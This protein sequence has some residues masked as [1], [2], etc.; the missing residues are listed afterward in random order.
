M[1]NNEEVIGMLNKAVIE[2]DIEAVDKIINKP[3]F[4][5]ITFNDRRYSPLHIAAWNGREEITKM[6]IKAGADVNSRES[7]TGK[8]PIF[9]AY[10]YEIIKGL[11]DA[12]ADVNIQDTHEYNTVLHGHFFDHDSLKLF[13]DAGFNSRLTNR[14]GWDVLHTHTAYEHYWLLEALLNYGLD[15]DRQNSSGQT[16]M[17]I[18]SLYG[19]KQCYTVLERYKLRDATSQRFVDQADGLGL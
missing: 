4:D 2:D 16:A 9:N 11:I 18:A 7:V 12:G 13:F 1:L 15:V 19:F 3:G 17:E 8:T 6:L 10:S 5:L 14:M